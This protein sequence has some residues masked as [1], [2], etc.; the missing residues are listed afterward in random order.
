MVLSLE[1]RLAN[2]K[3]RNKRYQSQSF[4]WLFGKFEVEWREW[5][6]N[7]GTWTVS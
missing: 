2:G 5:T 3:S 7:R 4:A 6:V 1:I